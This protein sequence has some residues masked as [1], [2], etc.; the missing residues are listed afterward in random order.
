MYLDS[1]LHPI[2]IHL[3]SQD[4]RWI[5]LQHH[6]VFLLDLV[7]DL[8][9]ELYRSR[10]SDEVIHMNSHDHGLFIFANDKHQVVVDALLEAHLDKVI[11]QGLVGFS[12]SLLRLIQSLIQTPCRQ[13]L[14][15]RFFIAFDLMHVVTSSLSRPAIQEE[16]FDVPM[17]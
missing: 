7:H 14:W 1:A 6:L 3:T 13:L 5:L 2:T 8:V 10:S 15:A 12:C 11:D 16:C 17:Q 4:H 9:L